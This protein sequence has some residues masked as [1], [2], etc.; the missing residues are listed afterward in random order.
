MRRCMVSEQYCKSK[1][2]TVAALL[3]EGSGF[4]SCLLPAFSRFISK[5]SVMVL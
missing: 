4:D 1:T 2:V 3:Q 5:L